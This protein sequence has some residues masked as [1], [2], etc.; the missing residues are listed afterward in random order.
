MGQSDQKTLLKKEKKKKKSMKE[1]EGK[2][3]KRSLF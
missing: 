3:Y 1:K 2:R